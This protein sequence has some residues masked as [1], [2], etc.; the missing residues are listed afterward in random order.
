MTF[1]LIIP[2][3]EFLCRPLIVR[4]KDRFTVL[5]NNLIYEYATSLDMK[6]SNMLIFSE[7]TKMLKKLNYPSHS[8]PPPYFL[9]QMLQSTWRECSLGVGL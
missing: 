7:K 4:T 1:L 6:W 9:S 3:H 2:L 8:S 5:V